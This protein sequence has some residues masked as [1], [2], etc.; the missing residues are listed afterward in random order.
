MNR[1][2]SQSTERAIYH[3]HISLCISPAR[4][5]KR[6]FIRVKYYN[7][8]VRIHDILALVMEREMFDTFMSTLAQETN[9]AL[10]DLLSN[11]PQDCGTQEQFP[12]TIFQ[13]HMGEF[14]VYFKKAMTGQ[15]WSMYI[16]NGKQSAQGSD[17]NSTYQRC[18]WLHQHTARND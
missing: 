15:Y 16:H 17:A 13:H 3:R 4:P 18:R 11:V 6:S 10:N 2:I 1:Y 7:Q 14:D 12:E 5:P 9:D 8:C